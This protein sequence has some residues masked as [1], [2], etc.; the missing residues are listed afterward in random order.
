[1]KM[2]PNYV[3]VILNAFAPTL[4][5][6]TFKSCDGINLMDLIHCRQLES[7]FI[8]NCRVS[9]SLAETKVEP[10]R[11]NPSSFL[12]HLKSVKSDI[13]LGL[14]SSLLEGKSELT[15]VFLNCFHN[16]TKVKSINLISFK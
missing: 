10:S 7:L 15:H 13:C 1:M 8:L 5:H 12:P 14:W 2:P 6:L 11:L 16:G 3:K 4:K 9:S